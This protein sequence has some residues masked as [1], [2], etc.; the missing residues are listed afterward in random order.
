MIIMQYVMF[1]HLCTVYRY[2]VEKDTTNN[3]VFVSRNYFSVDKKRRLFRVGSLKWL[4]GSS[5]GNIS[6]LQCKVCS[7]L[8]TRH[9]T[10]KNEQSLQTNLISRNFHKIVITT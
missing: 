1:L 9:A 8:L 5:P 10:G 2:V 3:V 4:S 7:F 6:Q